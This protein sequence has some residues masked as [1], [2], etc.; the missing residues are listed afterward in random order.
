M[1]HQPL[2]ELDAGKKMLQSELM[3]VR[4]KLNKIQIGTT[5]QN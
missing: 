1:M 2:F 5:T 3:V 4:E